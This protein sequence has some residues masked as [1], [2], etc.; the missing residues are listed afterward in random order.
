MSCIKAF[1]DSGILS[2]SFDFRSRFFQNLFS[3]MEEEMP[4][5]IF[6]EGLPTKED[7]NKWSENK[8][9]MLLVLDDLLSDAAN[10][11][12]IMN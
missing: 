12:D 8:E 7:V 4:E 2:S 1:S 6:H 9:H 11:P 5:I 3:K 10:N